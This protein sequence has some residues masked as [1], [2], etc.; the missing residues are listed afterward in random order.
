MNPLKSCYDGLGP[1]LSFSLPNFKTIRSNCCSLS[2]KITTV[3]V[4]QYCDT[5]AQLVR[6]VFNQSNLN[7]LIS[8]I[9]KTVLYILNQ[10]DYYKA[11]IIGPAISMVALVV[12][13]LSLDKRAPTSGPVYIAIFVAVAALI[14]VWAVQFFKHPPHQ[15][16]IKDRGFI[17][18]LEQVIPIG[19]P[20]VVAAMHSRYFKTQDELEV[21]FKK[22][23]FEINNFTTEAEVTT[24]LNDFKNF[25]KW[26]TEKIKLSS[27]SDEETKR[28]LKRI[29]TSLFKQV[30]TNVVI[31]GKTEILQEFMRLETSNTWIK[32]ILTDA[33][34]QNIYDQF[35]FRL[36]HLLKKQNLIELF[37]K[38]T[39]LD[40]TV[41]CMDALVTDNQ[42]RIIELTNE[43][44]IDS[45]KRTVNAPQG[46]DVLSA[47]HFK[48]RSMNL[49]QA[50]VLMGNV[51]NLERI[52]ASL[53]SDI[54]WDQTDSLH[55]NLLELAAL[56]GS[57]P[58]WEF[59]KQR[60]DKQ[61]PK[62]DSAQYLNLIYAAIKGK[63]I[64]I[65]RPLLAFIFEP[66]Y[67]DLVGALIVDLYAKSLVFEATECIEL[68]K[69]HDVFDQELQRSENIQTV[70]IA[71][72][73]AQNTDLVR[74]K[75]GQIHVGPQERD[76]FVKQLYEQACKADKPSSQL[77]EIIQ[78][79]EQSWAGDSGL[80]LNLQLHAEQLAKSAC[81]L[82]DKTLG[83]ILSRIS[84]KDIIQGLS[85]NSLF[86]QK[87]ITKSASLSIVLEKCATEKLLKVAL[88]KE[89]IKR[90]RIDALKIL[91]DDGL[92]TTKKLPDSDESLLSYSLLSFNPE[93]I[94]VILSRCLSLDPGS[95]QKLKKRLADLKSSTEN[96][97][98]YA[99]ILSYLD[100][101]SLQKASPSTPGSQA[102]LAS[103]KAEALDFSES[104]TAYV[105][106]TD[107]PGS[108]IA[109]RIR[110]LGWM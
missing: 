43:H 54:D 105:S 33:E 11:Y 44:A 107:A 28:V 65:I 14:T 82:N 19:T 83:F 69:T 73:R 84:E 98:D 23:G 66:S 4:S 90:H 38:P 89:A 68:L 64:A 92:D 99:R 102:I 41:L 1:Y 10:L 40:T 12:V 106:D 60:S 6:G 94:E 34:K 36:A 13:R 108:I 52:L 25:C 104:N 61:L 2:S 20:K 91:C 24:K 101:K 8:L 78:D 80:P 26:V 95:I 87:L 86:L 15:K 109:S 5:V 42:Q 7:K 50:A 93:L 63:N 17:G 62:V 16:I 75:L 81:Y 67:K 88:A 70:L 47:C 55:L 32:L 72:L 9:Q 58:M 39:G 27:S 85:G 30:L 46:D 29:L 71:A 51:F 56:S 48:M 49:V 18:A 35:G 53:S 31:Y 59:V 97:A 76:L 45:S 103:M 100:A 96:E 79:Y 3:P 21:L 77:I 74:E 110:F 57:E 22:P 37:E